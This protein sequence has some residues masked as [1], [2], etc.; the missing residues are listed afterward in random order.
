[1]AE[2]SGTKIIAFIT[3]CIILITMSKSG[4]IE[5]DNHDDSKREN[6][7]VS[8][9][10]VHVNDIWIW[11]VVEWKSIPIDSFILIPTLSLKDGSL[12]EPRY[13][14]IEE[15]KNISIIDSKYGKALRYNV[16]STN[17]YTEGDKG[18]SIITIPYIVGTADFVFN[19]WDEMDIKDRFFKDGPGF[20]IWEEKGG[21]VTT[22]TYVD[23]EANWIRLYLERA[24]DMNDD[25][26]WGIFDCYKGITYEIEGSGWF[27]IEL[28]RKTSFPMD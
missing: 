17:V 4:C 2:K 13:D 11:F 20:S 6:H 26:S 8:K 21:K 15:N 12:I 24:G 22:W 14:L 16:T 28:E 1:M 5:R 10:D 7:D 25:H 3:I 19:T 9:K 27:N 18:L 23:G